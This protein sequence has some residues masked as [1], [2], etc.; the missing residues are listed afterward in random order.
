MA[1][2]L[3]GQQTLSLHC[4]RSA[5]CPWCSCQ[6]CI[7]SLELAWLVPSHG[8]MS[9]HVFSGVVGGGNQAFF[10]QK[11]AYLATFIGFCHWEKVCGFQCESS[12]CAPPPPAH[13]PSRALSSNNLSKWT[14]TPFA[15]LSLT[16]FRQH[17]GED[18]NRIGQKWRPSGCLVVATDMQKT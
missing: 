13:L 1:V 16:I 18:E 11:A 5:I 8:L 14:R 12:C 2:T 9:S 4:A 7:L 17:T 3:L 15:Q 10:S 6:L